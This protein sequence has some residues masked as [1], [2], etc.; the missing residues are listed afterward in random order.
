VLS[1]ISGIPGGIFAPSLAVGAG[2]GHDLMPLFRSVAAPGSIYALCMAAFLA[3]IT[4]APITSFI[5]VMEMID[6]HEMVI[7]LMAVTLLSSLVARLFSPPLYHALA[8]AMAPVTVPAPAAVTASAT[9]PPVSA[10][11]KE[12]V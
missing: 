10:P 8:Q 12:T 6:G 5:I 7:S 4:Q 1:Y 3:A 11:A 2:I 9:T